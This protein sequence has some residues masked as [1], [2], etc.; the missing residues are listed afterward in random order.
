MIKEQYQPSSE[1]IQK[2]EGM[3]SKQQA[4]GSAH[5]EKGYDLLGLKEK[6]RNELGRPILIEKPL[7]VSEMAEMLFERYKSAT[8][9]I[10]AGFDSRKSVKDE[11]GNALMHISYDDSQIIGQKFNQDG[12][13]FHKKRS[14]LLGQDYGDNY[15]SFLSAFVHEYLN[16]AKDYIKN[17]RHLN[18]KDKIKTAKKLADLFDHEFWQGSRNEY[19][20]HGD[21]FRKYLGQMVEELTEELEK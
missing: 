5:R 14:L 20:A 6:L 15:G 21:A 18:K 4:K 11:A 17:S 12:D 2:A 3:M 8:R 13:R 10:T 1:E 9:E 19:E 16:I 7:D